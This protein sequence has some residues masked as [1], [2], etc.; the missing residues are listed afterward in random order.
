MNED[1][2]YEGVYN[3]WDTNNG[4]YLEEDEILAGTYDFWDVHDGIVDKYEYDE[5]SSGFC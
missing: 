4:N 2:L 5:A 3:T 1:E